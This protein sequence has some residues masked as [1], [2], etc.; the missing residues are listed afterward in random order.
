MAA[1]PAI[2]TVASTPAVSL[3]GGI[4]AVKVW[5]GGNGLGGGVVGG[6]RRV[7]AAGVVHRPAGVERQFAV[8]GGVESRRV[9]AGQILLEH[10]EVFPRKR[11][12]MVVVA[13]Q[14]FWLELMD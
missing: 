13:D 12:D 9:L 7:E 2:P 1:G 6:M 5:R 11:L 14:C 10:L 8:M 3:A 4:P